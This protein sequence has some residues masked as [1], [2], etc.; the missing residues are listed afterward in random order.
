MCVCERDI[1]RERERE[2]EKDNERE[3]ERKRERYITKVENNVS[4]F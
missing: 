2:G 3:R 1:R 4:T